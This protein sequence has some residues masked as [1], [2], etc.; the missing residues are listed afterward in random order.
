MVSAYLFYQD[1]CE[2]AFNY[3]AKVLG[4]KIDAMMRLSDA[5]PSDMPPGPPGREKTIMHARL[6]LPDGAVLMGSD[7][8]PEHFHKPQG[9]SI[10]VTVADPAEGEHKFNALAD[11]G[12]VT[13]PF[14]KTFWA[15]GFGMCVDKFGIPWMMN[16]PAEGM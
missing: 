4:G 16:C 11:G 3:Y 6:S 5:P 1:T 10:S 12:T 2:A 15:K 13:M 8:P 9:F 14:G 7:T